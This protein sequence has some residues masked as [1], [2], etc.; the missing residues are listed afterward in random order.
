[1]KG[2]ERER[3]RKREKVQVS[4]KGE[5]Q[6]TFDLT[7]LENGEPLD[8]PFAFISAPFVLCPTM[9]GKINGPV[10]QI[11]RLGAGTGTGLP[12]AKKTEIRRE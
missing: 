6:F 5:R 1:M 7:H 10:D 9:I 4:E 2:E 3:E 8:L 11:E 12:F